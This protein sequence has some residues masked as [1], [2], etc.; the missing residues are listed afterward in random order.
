[1]TAS[2]GTGADTA[3]P[4]PQ[5]QPAA[6][7]A[8]PPRRL[9]GDY[10]RLL[11]ASTSANTADGIFQVALPLMAAALTR[12]PALIAAVAFA[13]R[14]PWL[15]VA[16]PAG[17]L[18]DR[19]DRR[20]TM[21]L[22]QVGR[23]VVLGGLALMTALDLTSIWLLIVVALILGVGETLFDTASQSIM[24]AL[25]H[26]DQLSTANGRLYAAELTANQF[27]GPPLGGL[28]VG[29]AVAGAALAFGASAALFV[30]AGAL[31]LT[32]RGSF[33][34]ERQPGAARRGLWADVVEGVRYLAG[35]RLLAT[36]GIMTGTGNLCF[37]AMTSVFVLYATGPGSAMGLTESQFG[38]LMTGF[39][40]G[41]VLGS[42]V[43]PR[44]ERWLGRANLLMAAV[45]SMAA[46]LL[47]PALT[48]DPIVIAAAF[49]LGSAMIVAWNV[50]TVSLRQRITPDRL[51]GRV[52][53]GY[54]VLAWGS[55]PIG[56]ALGG[57]LAEA[58]GL[59]VTFAVT[60][61]LSA[62]LLFL[63]PLI[64]NR[65]I[66]AAEAAAEATTEASRTD[67]AG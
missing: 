4:R 6:T 59:R 36:L 63:R 58:F 32:L 21:V 38:L 34:P 2:S 53:A 25:V 54:R 46:T 9:G 31:L 49:C 5:P 18:A 42:L 17:A 62:V 66:A 22:V 52:N 23:T 19:L 60:A 67:A 43:T 47:V 33:R 26:R 35:H 30:I 28:L 3:Q 64:T 50:V 27:V 29:A 15:V 7:P 13:A 55:M 14:L 44:L 39:G 45:A 51:L 56:A 65:R 41:S 61:A 12:S 57:V 16:L 1:M 20:R 40:I 48:S 8:G 37:T 11:A 24:P 10:Y